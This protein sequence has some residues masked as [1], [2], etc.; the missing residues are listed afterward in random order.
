MAT[1]KPRKSR[2]DRYDA[3]R[4][5]I[6]YDLNALFPYIMRGRN[7]S[8]AYYPIS[9]DA[10]ALLAYIDQN[11]GTDQAITVFEAVLLSLIKLMRLRPSLNR[12][13]IGRRLYQRRNIVLSFIARKQMTEDG[14]ETNVMVTIKPED[15]RAT[16]LAKLRGEIRI[17]R[18]DEA[19]A[20]DDLIGTFMRLPRGLL[21]LA[22][23]M[24]E[25]YDFYFDTPKFLR[26]VDP[27]RCSVYIANLG[28]VGLDAP[29]HHLFE[30]GTCSL[31]MSIGKI[32]P[33]VCVGEDGQPTVRTKIPL[34]VAL[35]ER[36]ADG[37]QDARALE[38]METY[39]MDPAQLEDLAPASLSPS[40]K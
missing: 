23:R 20:D 12:Y 25:W 40:H 18:S 16:I 30:W 38:L 19:K 35:D 29:Y 27:L 6:P 5:Q 10:E 17:A 11:R 31:F 13:I 32:E 8:I 21:R 26:G 3:T 4:V 24:L 1:T 7:D 14:E 9:L 37:Y 36:I 15:D 22:V 2:G 28:S 33:T 34:R 39:I